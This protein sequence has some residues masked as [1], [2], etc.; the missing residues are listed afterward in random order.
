[1]TD[2]HISVSEASE[3]PIQSAW[4]CRCIG[5]ETIGGLEIIEEENPE[6][7]LFSSVTTEVKV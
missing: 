4:V 6:T 7:R 1:M 3:D 5:E 2:D